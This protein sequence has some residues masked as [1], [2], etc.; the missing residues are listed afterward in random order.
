MK[1]RHILECHASAIR[2]EH[3]E[4]ASLIYNPIVLDIKLRDSE[5]GPLSN[6]RWQSSKATNPHLNIEKGSRKIQ[7]MSGIDAT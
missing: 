4:T 5:I 3:F 1:N 7:F 2:S 6:Y